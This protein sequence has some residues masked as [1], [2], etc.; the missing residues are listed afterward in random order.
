M[1]LCWSTIYVKNMGESLKFYSEFIGLNI[2]HR[3]TQPDV[4]MV[5]LGE[6]GQAYLELIE[7]KA[8]EKVNLAGSYSI[9]LQVENGQDIV[10][11]LKAEGY[12]LLGGPIK[13]NVI[14]KFWVVQDPDGLKVQLVEIN[15]DL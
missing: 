3:Q 15:D 7:D 10:D 9:G 11:K 12:T 6:D 8:V 2:H 14:T 4:D 13:P 1:R 5:Y